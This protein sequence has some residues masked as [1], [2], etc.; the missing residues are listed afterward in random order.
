[1]GLARLLLAGVAVLVVVALIV[2]GVFALIGSLNTE[3]PA[4]DDPPAAV[5]SSEVAGPS[6]APSTSPAS[7]SSAPPA[8]GAAPTLFVECR[9]DSCPLFVRVSGGDIVEDRDLTRGQQAT[10]DQPRLDVVIG[11]AST[12]YVEVNG[13]PRDPGGPG[14]RQT[15][16][17]ERPG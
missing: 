10:Y 13:K 12:V 6:A 7:A 17:A 1:M 8:A 14:E 16:T 4:P 3:A 2:L 9:A 15:F 5:V 11:D